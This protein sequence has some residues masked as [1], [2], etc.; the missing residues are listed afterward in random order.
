VVLQTASTLTLSVDKKLPADHISVHV[1]FKMS[2]TPEM[3]E[4]YESIEISLTC[5]RDSV[6]YQATL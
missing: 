1:I 4:M 2:E 6:N 5:G 3:F